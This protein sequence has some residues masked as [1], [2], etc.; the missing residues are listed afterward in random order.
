VYD[1]DQKKGWLK[2]QLEPGYSSQQEFA[3]ITGFG[4]GPLLR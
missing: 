4:I 3:K 1:K 2:V